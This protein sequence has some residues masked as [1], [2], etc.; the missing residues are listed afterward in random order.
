LLIP[1]LGAVIVSNVNG[2][3][4][5]DGISVGNILEPVFERLKLAEQLAVLG[6]RV[7]ADDR[8]KQG[9]PGTP[10]AASP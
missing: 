5:D 9:L 4:G 6:G 3:F 1:T 10:R 8:E 2:A 7:V